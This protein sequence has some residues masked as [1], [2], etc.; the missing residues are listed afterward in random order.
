MTHL[1]HDQRSMSEST[2]TA[3]A[4]DKAGK[5][6]KLGSQPKTDSLETLKVGTS[7][8]ADVLLAL[9]QPRGEGAARFTF[10]PNLRNIWFYEYAEAAGSFTRQK[11]LL[12]F[13]NEQ[14]YEGHLWSSSVQER[15]IASRA[16][17]R[18]NTDVLEKS[19]SLGEST[20]ADV[21]SVLGEPSGKGRA[22]LPMD[23]KRRTISIWSYFYMEATQQEARG[24]WLFVYFDED[25][26]D[27][28]MWFSSLPKEQR[29]LL[30]PKEMSR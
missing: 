4:R 15:P 23:P 13:F 10:G 12:V 21:V 30:S 8:H 25:R 16:G 9:G 24:M 5:T 11:T 17:S 20:R 27:G 22:E 29:S 6:I 26:Y 3:S 28:Y 2:P 18:P 19:F 14:K 1:L 7:I